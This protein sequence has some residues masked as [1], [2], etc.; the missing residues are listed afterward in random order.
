MINNLNRW[1]CMDLARGQ[2]GGTTFCRWLSGGLAVDLRQAPLLQEEAAQGA[3]VIENSAAGSHV[4]L[5]LVHIKK[6]KLKGFLAAVRAVGGRQRD[7][8][9]DF[10]ERDFNGF[11]E[12]SDVFV[13][14]F[15][16]VERSLG[17]M[18]HLQ[19]S[20]NAKCPGMCRLCRLS[21]F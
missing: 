4:T 20:S 21:H 8:R 11:G 3:Q 19:V 9:L 2:L 14:T 5:Q 17:A 12:E 1:K 13:G 16:V 7:V 18:A 15:D 6:H 10:G